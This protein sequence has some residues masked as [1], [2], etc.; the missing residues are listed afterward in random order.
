M[1]ITR[2]DG[3]DLNVHDFFANEMFLQLSS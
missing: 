1:Y 3:V 2:G